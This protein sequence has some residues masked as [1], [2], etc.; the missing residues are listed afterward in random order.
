MP[1]NVFIDVA[2]TVAVAQSAAR[3][4]R[5]DPEEPRQ[6]ADI[7]ITDGDASV[8]AAVARTL[9][10]IE[11]HAPPSLKVDREIRR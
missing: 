10:A 4:A 2:C 3:E 6:P 11:F 1:Q 7:V 8:T 5:A 9:G